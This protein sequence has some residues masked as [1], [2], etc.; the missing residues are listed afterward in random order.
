MAMRTLRALRLGGWLLIAGSAA[1]VCGQVPSSVDAS[2]L[3][4]AL[5]PVLTAV[6]AAPSALASVPYAWRG[7]EAEIEAFLRTAPIE[8]FKDIPVGITKPR[9]GYFA[10]GGPVGS[11]AWKPIMPGMLHGK[12]ESYRSEI[13]AYLL[14]RHLG[15]HMVPPVVERRIGGVAGA[16]VYWIDGVR[17]WNPSEP[18]KVSGARWS[19]QTS[20]MLMFDQLI[21]NIDRNQGNLLYDDEGRLY[22]I[23]HSR[24]FVVQPGLGTL[25]P[26]QQFDRELWKRMAALTREDLDAVLK[27]WVDGNQIA[28]LLKRRDEMQKHIDRQVQKR[29]EAVT[30]LPPEPVTVTAALR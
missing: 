15:L 5:T 13:A 16:A 18:P 19:R 20:R 10:P 28:S 24:A 11:M 30:F 6:P 21:A 25:K 7:H 3:G 4:G 14:S 29:G 27:P 1:P 17:P 22:L 9:R 12:M 2:A 8:R 26:P 23:D